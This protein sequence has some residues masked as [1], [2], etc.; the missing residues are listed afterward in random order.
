MSTTPPVTTAAAPAQ[1]PQGGFWSIP[2]ILLCYVVLTTVINVFKRQEVLQHDLVLGEVENSVAEELGTVL[3]TASVQHESPSQFQKTF[4][5]IDADAKLPVF[6]TKN[7]QGK[8]LGAH[9]NL[10]KADEIVDLYLYITPDFYFDLDRH[11]LDRVWKLDHIPYNWSFTGSP[12][13]SW[14]L[15]LT[16]KM[17]A[18]YQSSVGLSVSSSVPTATATT[19]VDISDT[20]GES[21]HD[22]HSH[23]ETASS[24][25]SVDPTRQKS[26]Y[27]HVF[28]VKA[29]QTMNTSS[30]EYNPN[31]VAYERFNLIRHRKKKVEKKTYKLLE[32][33]NETEDTDTDTDTDTE[34]ES[35]STA[36]N[37]DADSQQLVPYFCP[38]LDI[39][40]VMDLPPYKRNDIPAVIAPLMHFN[41][42]GAYYP[43]IY[44]NDFFL[45]S[46]N[47][48]ELN[49][50]SHTEDLVLEIS[51]SHLSFLRW[52]MQTQME[53]QWKSQANMGVSS[54][55]TTDMIREV[56]F[57]TNPILLVVTCCVSILHSLFDFLAFKNDIQ[58]WRKKKNMAGLSVHS[59]GVNCFFQTVIFLYLMDNDTSW[60]ILISS[61]VGVVI[62][63]WKL[64]KAFNVTLSRQKPTESVPLLASETPSVSRLQDTKTE[65]STAESS[66]SQQSKYETLTENILVTSS[67][68]LTI[69]PASQV[70]QASFLG[71]SVSYQLSEAYTNSKTKEYDAIATTH[72][73]YVVLP[74]VFGYSVYSLLHISH[75]SFYSWFL[76]SLVGFVYAF[77]FVL[78]T[79]QLFI[80]YK[81]Q[82]VAH[83][84]RSTNA[85][86]IFCCFNI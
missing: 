11:V 80:N 23:S 31:S 55:Q 45:S 68:E 33:R 62:E 27:A 79:P 71:V 52:H 15:T 46:K 78:M 74:L 2:R 3:P 12:Q 73:L 84:V 41:E 47:L 21:S 70:K 29:N 8:R 48:I 19:A 1:Q 58:F 81:L 69:A 75:K 67:Q 4:L 72:L 60:M 22:A 40:L 57:D 13:L 50:S 6:P 64:G 59:L 16:T 42:L 65:A 20:P 63:F 28:L 38:T 49:E 37:G 51:Y 83:M 61:G 34:K 26:I 10:F 43:V 86:T 5:H 39:A 82:S 85:Y 35:A 30:A 36:E 24:S 25:P 7:A 56:L 18:D 66:D 9:R 54:E 44:H 76:G 77:G 53:Q 14:N 17:L 32:S